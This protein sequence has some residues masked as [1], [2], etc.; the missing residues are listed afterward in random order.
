MQS[1]DQRE[2]IHPVRSSK[3]MQRYTSLR[4]WVYLNIQCV[5]QYK[6]RKLCS[7]THKVFFFFMYPR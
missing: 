4:P 1:H 5:K 2:G 7:V 6:C 3:V